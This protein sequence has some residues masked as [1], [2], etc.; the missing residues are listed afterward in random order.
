MKL[1]ACSMVVRDADG[2][3]LVVREADPRV[4]G[5]INLPGGHLNPGETPAECAIRELT[6]ERI[7]REEK[8]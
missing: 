8:D 4:H 7:Y 3:I 1:I 5:K 2:R 6:E